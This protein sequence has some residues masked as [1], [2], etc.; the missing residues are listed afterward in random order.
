MQNEVNSL[1]SSFDLKYNQ[2]MAKTNEIKIPLNKII[3]SK[4]DNDKILENIRQINTILQYNRE[5]SINN[6]R[7]LKIFLEKNFDL[8]SVRIIIKI[9]TNLSKLLCFNFSLQLI[10]C[11]NF[12]KLLRNILKEKEI[13]EDDN[14][15]LIKCM[16]N[17]IEISGNHLSNEIKND[18]EDIE[19]KCFKEEIPKNKKIILLK[20]LIEFIKNSPMVFFN[21]ITKEND[22]L[23]NIILINFKNEDIDIRLTIS[24]LTYY[25]FCW[26]K[27]RD[28]NTKNNYFK[29]IYDLIINQFKSGI[30]EEPDINSLHGSILLIKSIILIKELFKS[31]SK[32]I[33]KILFKYKKSTFLPIK[34]KIIEYIPD[35]YDYLEDNEKLLEKFC[36]FLID[37]YMLS[38]KGS[39]ESNN[40]ILLS[41]KKLCTK[42]DKNIFE[43][44][45]DKFLLC[46]QNKFENEKYIINS[47]EIEF[48][49]ELFTNYSG[50]ILKRV[51]L[52]L[53]IDRIFE[54]GFNEIHVIFL[55]KVINLYSNQNKDEIKM[56]KIILISLNVTSLIL[57]KKID[58]INSFKHILQYFNTLTKSE[59]KSCFKEASTNTKTKIGQLLINYLERE[60]KNKSTFESV[61][62]KITLSAIRLLKIINHPCFAKDILFFYRK[63]C[64]PLLKQKI[65]SIQ[66]IE[67]IS[68]ITSDW[69]NIS[70]NDNE[71]NQ[72][73]EFILEDL[74]IFYLKIKNENI[75]K[76]ILE[77][78][79]ERF[80][81]IL[82][83]EGFL[84]KLFFIFEFEES[85]LKVDIMRILNRLKK[86]IP[87]ISNFLKKE[88]TRIFTV[89]KFSYNIFEKEKEISL[90][91]F[92][93]TNL[94]DIILEYFDKTIFEIL[95]KEINS[96]KDFYYNQS[97]S[98]SD[99]KEKE[100]KDDLNLKIASILIELVS[101]SYHF[102]KIN[103]EKKIA[104]I[105]F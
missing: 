93:I 57:S 32:E 43:I 9:F 88:I 95:I 74:L 34:N 96:N 24:D 7:E 102:F 60:Q 10:L 13:T 38:N 25:F 82:T 1:E 49:S 33:F 80:D 16:G 64:F 100:C 55:E 77:N 20:I 8:L 54:C 87:I 5:D 105:K 51:N 35:L 6:I 31:K 2:D 67:I 85:S 50:L 4:N 63:N 81:A 14:E 12:Y 44:T 19:T 94:K 86:Y 36:N 22:C 72:T 92:Y 61:K 89:L 58:L 75:K 18:I 47:N 41:L 76:S 65:K 21:Q 48:L 30:N 84:K 66:K 27:N 70:K 53:I 29:I 45:A 3:E 39:N 101:S 91:S 99:I 97:F 23:I 73:I 79:D 104:T 17:L 68:L 71:I 26:L 52:D 11:S 37:D 78:L 28:I 42:I 90:L 69:F 98:M 56:L 103:K 62:L 83:K 46:F 59:A 40:S 15:K